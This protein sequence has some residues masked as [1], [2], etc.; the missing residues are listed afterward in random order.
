MVT[1]QTFSLRLRHA[2]PAGAS[3]GRPR[4]FG[5]VL[6]PVVQLQDMP[7]LA[8]ALHRSAAGP[9]PRAVHRIGGGAQ[10][11]PAA[12]PRVLNNSASLQAVYLP[13]GPFRAPVCTRI[14]G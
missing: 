10:G 12:M 7:T 8:A 11:G 4:G 6:L 9:P 2:E 14:L 1:K 3:S 5:Y 13:D